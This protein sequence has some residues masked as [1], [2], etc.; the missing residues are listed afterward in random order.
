MFKEGDTEHESVGGLYSDLVHTKSKLEYIGQKLNNNK[1]QFFVQNK[2]AEK[3][4]YVQNPEY[5]GKVG[6]AVID[7]GITLRMHTGASLNKPK[8]N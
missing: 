7:L 8:I 6:K 1:Q 5:Q 3:A 4:L 2:I